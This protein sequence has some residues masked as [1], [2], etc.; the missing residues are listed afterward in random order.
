MESRSSPIHG[1]G[2]FAT[3]DIAEGEEF[4]LLEYAKVHLER[5]GSNFGGFNHSS[6]PNIENCKTPNLYAIRF[7]HKGEELTVD[8]HLAPGELP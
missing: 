8:Y 5:Y 6:E 3:D 7:I 4:C 1:I 2:A